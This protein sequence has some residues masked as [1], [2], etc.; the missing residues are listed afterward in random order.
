MPKIV[1]HKENNFTILSNTIF[2]DNRL[3]LKAVGLLCKMLSLPDDWDYS[4][5]GLCSI[6]KEKESA[7]TNALSE[8]KE[9]G[10]VVVER[11]NPDQTDSGRIEY[12]YHIYEEPVSSETKT[13]P[14]KQ[15]GRNKGLETTPLINNKDKEHT[16]DRASPATPETK[17]PSS[18]KLFSTQPQPRRTSAVQKINNFI[19]MCERV[20]GKYD[21]DSAT[22]TALSEFFRMLGASNTL[23]PEQTI[24]EQLRRLSNADKQFQEKI[25]KDTISHGWKSLVYLADEYKNGA[26]PSFDTAV[27]SKF[28][29]KSEED[30]KRNL[31]EEADPDD[32]F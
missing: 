11:F 6:C 29:P 10:Y 3:S 7:I 16:Y 21:F 19:T 17:R 27:D 24:A 4:I 13:S 30:K 1:V 26:R 5:A 15:G 22:R 2:K 12:T 32:V 8:L 31:V 14:P 23:L 9:C 28:T 20:S 25:V 18:G